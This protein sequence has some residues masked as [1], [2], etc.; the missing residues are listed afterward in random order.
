[1]FAYLQQTQTLMHYAAL[2]KQL[3]KEWE[4]INSNENDLNL[5][6]FNTILKIVKLV[7]QIYCEVYIL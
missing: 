6:C 7:G 3:Q 2:Q 1:M 4:K 5:K